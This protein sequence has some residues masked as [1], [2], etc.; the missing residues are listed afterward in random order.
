[1]GYRAFPPEQIMHFSECVLK[2]HQNSEFQLDFFPA[3]A[4]LKGVS[5]NECVSIGIFSRTIP[6]TC[7]SA[8]LLSVSL[9]ILG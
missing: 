9:T 2:V 5:S 6:C 3:G 1:M 4:I 8:D 7:A